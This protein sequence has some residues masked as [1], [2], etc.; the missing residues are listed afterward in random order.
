LERVWDSVCG[1]STL[2]SDLPEY[3]FI[4]VGS[5]FKLGDIVTF[6]KR[7]TVDLPDYGVIGNENKHNGAHHRDVSEFVYMI[8]NETD[9]QVDHDHIS[10]F[11]LE[12]YD[13]ELPHEQRYLKYISLHCKGERRMSDELVQQ[14]DRD[15]CWD[16]DGYYEEGDEIT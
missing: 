14:I 8:D 15:G 4:N 10:P 1:M 16:W 5:P 12:R 3:R 2:N 6:P 7:R 13:G 9:Y 11:F